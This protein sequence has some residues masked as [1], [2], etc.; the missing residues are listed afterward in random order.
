MLVYKDCLLLQCCCC[1]AT[2]TTDSFVVSRKPN[3]ITLSLWYACMSTFHTRRLNMYYFVIL[4]LCS[5]WYNFQKSFKK[6]TRIQTIHVFPRLSD[7][8]LQDNNNKHLTPNQYMSIAYSFSPIYAL[9][10]NTWV[11][12]SLQCQKKPNWSRNGCR[13]NKALTD[14]CLDNHIRAQS[15]AVRCR[16]FFKSS[17]TFDKHQSMATRQV[18]TVIQL[19]LE[20]TST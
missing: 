6:S 19:M 8:R 12:W 15:C 4:Q 9:K 11:M 5:A 18:F 14:F 20:C 2:L 7:A 13:R 10:T 17:K 3:K 16:I 1:H